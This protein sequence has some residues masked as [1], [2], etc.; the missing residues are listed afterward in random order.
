MILFDNWNLCNVDKQTF[1]SLFSY[2]KS[3]LKESTC[4]FNVK[5]TV[6]PWEDHVIL[7]DMNLEEEF[8]EVK[9]KNQRRF[10]Y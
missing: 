6:N 5:N 7:T 1:T 10:A 8:G 3:K 4:S 2:V 9:K